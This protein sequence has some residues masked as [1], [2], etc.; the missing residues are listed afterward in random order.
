MQEFKYTQAY[1]FAWLDMRHKQLDIHNDPIWKLPQLFA[2][3]FYCS[4]VRKDSEPISIQ[5]IF[6]I[7]KNKNY[8]MIIVINVSVYQYDTCIIYNLPIQS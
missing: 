8:V 1:T 7:K 6:E 3:I 5:F 4:D 2:I